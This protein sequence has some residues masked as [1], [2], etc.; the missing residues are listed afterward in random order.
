[1][2]FTLHWQMATRF[3]DRDRLAAGREIEN[4]LTGSTSWVKMNGESCE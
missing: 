2:A 4:L 3:P 1:M